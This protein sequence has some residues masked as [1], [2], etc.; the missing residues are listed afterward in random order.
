M[1]VRDIPP[2][3]TMSIFSNVQFSFFCYLATLAWQCLAMSSAMAVGMRVLDLAATAAAMYYIHSPCYLLW[4][5]C[6]QA[7]LC[8]F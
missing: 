3:L 6:N 8:F 4:F 7:V 2:L 1:P 5:P